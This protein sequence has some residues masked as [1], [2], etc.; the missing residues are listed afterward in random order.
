MEKTAAEIQAENELLAKAEEADL[1]NQNGQVKTSAEIAAELQEKYK[2]LEPADMILKISED[3]AKKNEI[4]SHKN[5]AINALKQPK[6]EPEPAPAAT[7]QPDDIEAKM[8]EFFDKKFGASQQIA[9]VEQ[10]ISSLTTDASEQAKIREAYNNSIVKSGNVE[11]DLKNAL[12]IAN[13][14]IIEDYRKTKSEAEMNE[15]IMTKFMVGQP[16]GGGEDGNPLNDPVKK[17]AYENMLKA[18]V[19]A[20]AAMKAIK[21]M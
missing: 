4:I 9:A 14:S 3:L 18:G 2:D 13:A 12:A 10:K 6:K 11:V 21:N 7:V 15:V 5:R 8:N 1:V 19:S 16:S 17:G 20:E